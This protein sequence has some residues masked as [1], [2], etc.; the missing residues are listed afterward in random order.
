MRHQVVL[1][2]K[3]EAGEMGQA[4]WLKESFGLSTGED[5]VV[6]RHVLMLRLKERLELVRG[7][8]MAGGLSVCQALTPGRKG[9]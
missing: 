9:H 1:E 4:G 6:P 5:V 2:R 8:L 3:V 7:E